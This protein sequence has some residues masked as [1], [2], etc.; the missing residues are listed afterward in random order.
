MDIGPTRAVVP[1]TEAMWTYTIET[2][3]SFQGLAR[4][5]WRPQGPIAVTGY[6]FVSAKLTG[7]VARARLLRDAKFIL[8]GLPLTPVNRGWM[9]QVREM[10]TP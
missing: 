6:R 4:T 10:H 8:F 5:P 2:P 7:S 9:H 3:N 1:P